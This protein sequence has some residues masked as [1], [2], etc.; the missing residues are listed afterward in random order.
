MDTWT[1]VLMLMGSPGYGISSAMISIP[2]YS[3][4]AECLA[5]SAAWVD[6]GAKRGR[7]YFGA[8][9]VPGPRQ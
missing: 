9:C 6:P 3:S 2:G 1:L 5:A 8:S 4:E 7:Y